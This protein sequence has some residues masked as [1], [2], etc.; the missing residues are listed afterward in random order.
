VPRTVGYLIDDLDV[1]D[2][3]TGLFVSHLTRVLLRL[4]RLDGAFFSAA[5]PKGAR[6]IGIVAEYGG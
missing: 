3:D 6:Y 2:A 1:P 5:P 4:L